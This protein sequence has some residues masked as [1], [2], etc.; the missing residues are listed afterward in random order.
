MSL[1]DILFPDFNDFKKI[2]PLLYGA[3]KGHFRAED[4][5]LGGLWKGLGSD[6]MADFHNKDAGDPNSALR[7]RLL[8]GALYLGGS[9]L[10]GGAGSFLGSGGGMAAGSGG[11]MGMPGMPGMSDQPQ[12]QPMPQQLP[13]NDQLNARREIEQLLALRRFGRG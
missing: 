4:K 2:D 10:A 9:A 12:Q 6:Q 11:G 5:L 1:K 3:G 13:L 8:G 7:H